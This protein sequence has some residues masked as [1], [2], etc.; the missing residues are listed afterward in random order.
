MLD[1]SSGNQVIRI[2][3]EELFITV[4]DLSKVIFTANLNELTFYGENAGVWI[5]FQSVGF[6]PDITYTIIQAEIISFAI[7]WYLENILRNTRMSLQLYDP[8]KPIQKN[9]K[10]VN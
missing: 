7:F 5:A 1:N 8:R 2:E 6:N 4:Y 10:L 9:N 3:G